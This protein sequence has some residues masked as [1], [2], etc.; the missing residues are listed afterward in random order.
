MKT[1]LPVAVETT[2]MW[3][4]TLPS[5]FFQLTVGVGTPLIV[6]LRVMSVP[7]MAKWSRAILA[8]SNSSGSSVDDKFYIQF[9]QILPMSIIMYLKKLHCTQS[10]MN[11]DRLLDVGGVR[12]AGSINGEDP[13]DKLLTIPQSC[14]YVM[15]VRALLWGTVCRNPFYSTRFLVF[16]QVAKDASFAVV[17]R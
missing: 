11:F 16:N 9:L 13:E 8:S 17:A 6:A 12:F 5:S 3:D 1:L 4:G 10:V 15:E 2:V 7:N 14:H